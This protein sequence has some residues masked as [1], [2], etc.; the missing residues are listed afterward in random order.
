MTYIDVFLD[1]TFVKWLGLV[2]IIATLVTIIANFLNWLT[3]GRLFKHLR[4]FL[5]HSL[6]V[7]PIKAALILREIE[8]TES[9][10]FLFGARAI[11]FSQRD[12]EKE[13]FK[14][15]LMDSDK[16][17]FRWMRIYGPGGVGKSR[18]ALEMCI[19]L[20]ATRNWQ[21][22]FLDLQTSKIDWSNWEPYKPTLIVIDYAASHLEN[23]G[24][25][26]Q[27][28]SNRSNSTASEPLQQSVRVLLL[29][30]K[31]G[32]AVSG[33]TSL[34]T[35]GQSVLQAGFLPDMELNTIDDPW[36]LIKDVITNGGGYLPDRDETMS[37]LVRI[38]PHRRPLF[39][40]FLADA[41]LSGRDP[42][43]FDAE[44][45]VQD[46]I[47]RDRKS[48]WVTSM[49]GPEERILSLATMTGGLDVSNYRTLQSAILPVWD[50]D[51]HPKKLE[52]MTGYFSSNRIFPLEPDIVG[53]HFINQVF[54]SAALGDADKKEL[55]ELAWS[56]D[57]AGVRRFIQKC[58]QDIPTSAFLTFLRYPPASNSKNEVQY[59]FGATA[60]L[61]SALNE[62]D[63][64]VAKTAIENLCDHADTAFWG[65]LAFVLGRTVRQ[66]DVESKLVDSLL[67]KLNT[68]PNGLT[69]RTDDPTLM[70][71][72]LDSILDSASRNGAHHLVQEICGSMDKNTAT[73][74][75]RAFDTPL[76]LL[77]GFMSTVGKLASNGSVA[78][79]LLSKLWCSIASDPYRLIGKSLQNHSVGA[80]GEI[81]AFVRLAYQSG[82]C[83]L[84]EEIWQVLSDNPEDFEQ[85]V[86]GTSTNLLTPFVSQAK[87]IETSLKIDASLLDNVWS[88]L[89][90]EID[91]LVDA[92]VETSPNSELGAFARL[93]E[94][95]ED[96]GKSNFVE[97]AREALK[98]KQ[99]ALVKCV[100]RTPLDQTKRFLSVAQ[101]CGMEA[102]LN[103]LLGAFSDQATIE[104]L[105]DNF[106][107]GGAL[108][109]L[110][111]LMNLDQSS[112]EIDLQYK[113]RALNDG[114]WEVL[115]GKTDELAKKISLSPFDKIG[116]FLS[117]VPYA[118]RENLIP[119][120]WNKLSSEDI[121]KEL[122]DSAA[123]S[124][125]TR[126]VLYALAMDH[127]QEWLVN[128][129][130]DV[131]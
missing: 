112:W 22:G 95:A 21:A 119:A 87:E 108:D 25:M 63:P 19:W 64:E 117:A 5:R 38:D 15:F 99:D 115:S 53:E 90:N 62:L 114:I 33:F 61:I 13:R 9:S 50:I 28:L 20:D 98:K 66:T 84:V 124:N 11:K 111:G 118:Y 72:A 31:N 81:S 58:G 92:T 8:L 101:R 35:A 51:D 68:A 127:M 47:G 83:N 129:L 100:A 36:L 130:D 67:G 52:R 41:I 102:L 88:Q 49:A 82:Q 105:T 106:L 37:H 123:A 109:G 69:K 79:Q 77:T 96:Q 120:I 128:R 125:Q 65:D 60:R 24:P 3:G 10:R 86:R 78:E 17:K 2:V 80:L 54:S 27:T 97:D 74:A 94:L 126:E 59:W 73:I 46:V 45:L 121:S 110:S 85:H 71:G 56:A 48:F 55:Y 70:L 75:E 39:A 91:R 7:D 32:E 26:L 12:S 29:D 34:G 122:V 131:G 44:R 113:L 4:R 16:T 18:F 6:F 116:P 42:T 43:S 93:I 104:E 57:P 107:S 23:V 89:T 76:H 30:R 14:E 1:S 40:H 103:G